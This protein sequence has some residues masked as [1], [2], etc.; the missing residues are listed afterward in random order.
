MQKTVRMKLELQRGAVPELVP[1]D[2]LY[3]LE[4]GSQHVLY[5][6]QV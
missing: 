4:V 1:P 5:V 3:A 2:V 6:I